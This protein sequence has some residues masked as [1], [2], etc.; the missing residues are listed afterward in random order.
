[1]LQ[2]YK[3]TTKSSKRIIIAIIECSRVV[4]WLH[5]N[6]IME[7]TVRKLNRYE[8]TRAINYLERKAILRDERDAVEELKELLQ[9]IKF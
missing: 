8:S 2:V 6:D 5:E 7:A 9:H 1:M 3:I 4:E